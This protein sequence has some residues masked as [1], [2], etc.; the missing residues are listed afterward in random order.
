MSTYESTLNTWL[1]EAL[2]DLG[3]EA[4]A[5]SGQGG[6]RRLDVEISYDGVK[7]AL[8]AEQGTTTTKIASAIKDADG[9]LRDDLADCAVALCYEDG[10]G[11]SEQ[12]RRSQAL[13]TVR[14]RKDRPPAAKTKWVNGNLEQLVS[15]I[16]QIPQ[17]LGDPDELA[18]S[19]SFSLD[20]AVDRLSEQQ[21][22]DLAAALDL[23]S[24]KPIKIEFGNAQTS[25]FNQAAK[26][27]MLVIAT[28]VMFQAQLDKHRRGI[29][30]LQDNRF[31][32]TVFYTGEWPPPLA[33]DC[34]ESGD[35]IGTFY[36]TWD[37]WLAVDYKPI[38][39]T[40][41]NALRGCAQDAAFS[42][43]VRRTAQG[44]LEVARNIAGIRHDLL[45]RI[46][47]RVL[48]TARYDG[49]F[50]TTTAAATLLA[51]LAI[52]EDMCDWSDWRTIARLR[53]TD[54]AC[55]TGTLLMAAAERI[56]DLSS[57]AQTPDVSRELIENV[58]T[59]YD[60]NLT[61]THLAAT[62]LG[63]LSPT[64]TF[65]EMKIGRALLGVD[66]GKAYLGSLEFLDETR[67]ALM[68][69]W[70]TGVE[71]M[72][73]EEEVSRTEPA[74]IVIMNPPFTANKLRHD[75]F[76]KEEEDALKRR[77]QVLF[78]GQPVHLSSNGNSFL[79]LANH[80]V[81]SEKG[82]VASVLPLVTATNASSLDIRKYLANHFH[83][84]TVIS[85]H[86]PGRLYFSENTTIT[87]MLLVC[88]RW[89]YDEEKP[90][91]RF[92]NLHEN[93][94]TPAEALGVANDIN[95]GNLENV[96]G[97]VQEWSCDRI[98][99]GNWGAVQFL[100]PYL[101]ESFI[102]L[103][104]GQLF[105]TR[106]LGQL[107]DISPD[108]RAIRD[109]FRRSDTSDSNAMLALWDHKT[110]YVQKMAA[111]HDTY[112]IA[113]SGKERQAKNNW[114]R[115]GSL[116]LAMRARLNTVKLVSVRLPQRALGS[117]WVPCKPSREPYPTDTDFWVETVEKAFCVYL[118]ST[119]GFLAILGNR[120]IRDLS[121]SQFSMDDLNKIPVP[122]FTQMDGQQLL[123]IVAA[124]DDLCDSELL[125][126]S[127]IM[128]CN[129]RQMLDDVVKTALGID[130]E[131][132]YRIRHQLSREPSITGKPYELEWD[133]A[134]NKPP[135]LSFW[136]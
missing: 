65:E 71:Q 12:L 54:P 36:D 23:P 34:V 102:R 126:L 40:A 98:T 1:A 10:I 48:E 127:Q 52:G 29:A 87:E 111:N 75:Q 49:S 50:Y 124:Y 117:A 89:P 61:A 11:T 86:D 9:R 96:K 13:Y 19:L 107:A 2:R 103:Q 47:H 112:I 135:Q 99:A 101:C 56:R 108:G 4:R 121:Y 80:I 77:E 6:G 15:V 74:D 118:N 33:I 132:V 30:P 72:E 70:P 45:G 115:R 110:D 28:A 79:V 31:A 67:P 129:T 51:N 16:R 100:S 95:R 22:Q 41:R 82:V 58:L 125:P 91:T 25:R 85:S 104:Q 20:R 42:A 106:E 64:T 116:L 76:S 32:H 88:R 18:A 37:M 131:T 114:A 39:A 17:Q 44:A 81:K 59:G 3:L 119:I 113:K 69:P 62:T 5:E 109:N 122:D 84:E 90:T 60:V 134:E 43:A 97:T 46:F 24:G 83:V 130:G 7:I 128:E 55:G 8:E 94:A 14:T 120:S 27:A 35:P 26:R 68:M 53:I 92:V 38:F 78:A 21:K 123:D 136:S 133:S 73:S 57:V 93:P 66:N 105:T 63:L